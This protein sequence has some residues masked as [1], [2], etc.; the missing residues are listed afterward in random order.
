MREGCVIAK[1]V[2]TAEQSTQQRQATAISIRDADGSLWLA[3]CGTALGQMM[4]LTD[5]NP[6]PTLL[7]CALTSQLR[8]SKS[9]FIVKGIPRS[10]KKD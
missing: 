8:S 5:I 6:W 10:E 9:G 2:V 7:G 4:R 3:F 1:H